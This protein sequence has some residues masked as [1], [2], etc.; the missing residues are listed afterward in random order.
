MSQNFAF[1]MLKRT[2]ASKKITT[3]VTIM[4][5][6]H[7]HDRNHREKKENAIGG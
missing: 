7:H 2:L 1:S 5:Y 4:S 6:G 3:V